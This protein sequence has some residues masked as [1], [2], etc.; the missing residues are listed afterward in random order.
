MLTLLLAATALPIAV[1]TP[2]R[3]AVE[4]ERAFARDAQRLGQW[5]AFRKYAD[6]DAVLF[7]P[8][9]VLAHEFLDGRKD[10]P[11]FGPLVAGAKLRSCDGRIAVNTGPWGRDRRQER[12]LFH[13]RV[14]A[15]K[16]GAGC[17]S[18]MA[19]KRSR[20]RARPRKIR[21]CAGFVQGQADPPA[22]SYAAPCTKRRASPRRAITGLSAR[23]TGPGVDWK[24]M[25]GRAAVPHVPWNGGRFEQVV[26]DRSP[27]RVTVQ[28]PM[29]RK[30]W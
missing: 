24:S 3:S 13:H 15:A 14:A 30:R 19:A 1:G 7:T 8:Q 29:I 25:Q 11:V 6:L 27:Q 26:H 9:V 12:R 20:L 2:V 23:P 21:L 4:A 10:P 18:M 17:G 16:S 5:T 22:I 28:L